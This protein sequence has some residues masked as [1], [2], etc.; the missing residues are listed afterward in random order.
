MRMESSE[1][2]FGKP[3]ERLKM[4]LKCDCCTSGYW[5]V[6]DEERAAVSSTLLFQNLPGLCSGS[7]QTLPEAVGGE[8]LQK[9]AAVGTVA[10]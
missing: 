8:G 5:D 10:S 1:I 9:P 6:E 2:K 7:D 4:T 3:L